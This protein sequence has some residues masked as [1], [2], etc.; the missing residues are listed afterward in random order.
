MYKPISVFL[1]IHLA[2]RVWKC[3][4]MAMPEWA[5]GKVLSVHSEIFPIVT[6]LETLL[7]QDSLADLCSQYC[8]ALDMWSADLLCQ[9]YT[10]CM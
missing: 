5:K 9:N 2:K 7:E 4:Q 1:K 3:V 10:E 6:H 8:E